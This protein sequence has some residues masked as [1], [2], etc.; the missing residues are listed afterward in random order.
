M[1]EETGQVVFSLDDTPEA[2][3]LAHDDSL[4]DQII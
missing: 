2:L 4:E 1:K 3:V